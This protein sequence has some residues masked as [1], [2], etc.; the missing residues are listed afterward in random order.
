MKLS[1]FTDKVRVVLHFY[2]QDAYKSV[3]CRDCED[4]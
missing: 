1:I 4:L 3:K 2:K